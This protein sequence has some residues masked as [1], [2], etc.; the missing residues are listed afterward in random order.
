MNY[1][2]DH[3]SYNRMLFDGKAETSAESEILLPDYFPAIMKIIRSE[4]VPFIRTRSV[5]GEKVVAEGNVEFRAAYLSEG[6]KLSSVF[7][8]VPFSCSIEVKDFDENL[9]VHLT[10]ATE[11]FDVRAL[12]PQKIHVKATA[13][14]YAKVLGCDML[15][16][17][18]VCE[19]AGEVEIKTKP[20]S[21]CK[22]TC[23]G[24]KTL[25]VSDEM[26]IVQKPRAKE[27]LSYYATFTEG[28]QKL[29]QN[30][31]IAKADM[32]LKVVYY[33]DTNDSIETFEQKV[34]ISQIIDISD[35]DEDT[36][37]NVSFDLADC[38]MQIK[39]DEEKSVISYDMEIAVSAS[40]YKTFSA[41]LIEDAFGVSKEIECISKTIRTE[42]AL[43]QNETVNFN[44]VVDIGVGNTLYDL[45]VTPRINRVYF[46]KESNSA[47]ISGVF[48]CAL[49]F[50]DSEEEI[51]TGMRSVPFTMKTELDNSVAD[52]RGE[53]TMAVQSSA[54]VAVEDNKTEFR[55]SCLVNGC[56]FVS[57]DSEVL[58]EINVLEEKQVNSDRNLVIYFAQK[59]ESIWDIAKKYSA[60][61]VSLMEENGIDGEVLAESKTMMIPIKG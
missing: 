12:S 10:A 36:L 20:V 19:G 8:K 49:V 44:E 14:V 27:I 11:Y 48:S 25:R 35:L 34:P 9:P 3:I 59:G 16:I 23:F 41:D 54:F 28:E 6:G 56:I 47:V 32:A 46:E 60:S 13:A 26:E 33:S 39:D 7:T 5:Y 40:G 30:K 61:P 58:S 57:E 31:I 50:I 1:T 52:V 4:A 15:P 55:V 2:S 42:K 37:C 22:N 43:P 18:S 21:Y 17:L 51:G 29:L 53:L 24:R 38:N 45:N